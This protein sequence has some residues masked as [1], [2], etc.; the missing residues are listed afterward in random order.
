MDEN[1]IDVNQKDTDNAEDPVGAK[2]EIVFVI[3]SIETVRYVEDVF[4]I[5]VLVTMEGIKDSAIDI[6]KSFEVVSIFTT[7]IMVELNIIVKDSD[8]IVVFAVLMVE[9]DRVIVSTEGVRYTVDISNTLVHAI[10][11]N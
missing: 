10:D 5:S 4:I 7:I 3:A 6:I 1:S 8:I 2:V 11:D 9:I